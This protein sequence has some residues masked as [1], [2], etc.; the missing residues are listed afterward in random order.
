MELEKFKVGTLLGVG[1]AAIVGLMVLTTVYLNYLSYSAQDIIQSSTS[2][3]FDVLTIQRDTDELFSALEDVE[4]MQDKGE[5]EAARVRFE[6]LYRRA[7]ETVDR[8]GEEGVFEEEEVVQAEK[9]LRDTREVAERVFAKKGA[10]IERREE[11]NESGDEDVEV[12]NREFKEMNQEFINA[13]NVGFGMSSL[14]HN[15]IMRSDEEFNGAMDLVQR[16]Q[17][18]TWVVVGVSVVMAITMGYFI[19]RFAKRSYDIK[20]EFIY[21]VAHDL[22]NPVVAII[23]YL[24]LIMTTKNMSR[25]QM[26]EPLQTIEV[27][28]QRL[29]TQIANM[30]EVGRTETGF[31]KLK[32]ESVQVAPVIEESVMRAKAL[33][34][35]KGL[36]MVYEQVAGKDVYVLADRSKL[37]DVL[38]NLISNA[39]KYNRE[40]GSVT[41][42]TEDTGSVFN[43][44]VTDTGH[45][46]PE[47]KR[48]KL[49]KKYSR[50]EAKT[51]KGVGGTG[52]GLYT[53]KL[54]MEKMEGEISFESVVGEGTTFTVTLKKASKG[55]EK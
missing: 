1:I 8:A 24:E 38:D 35:V 50:L 13:R 17:M 22:R 16:S 45:G 19:V 36:K 53:A 49:F 27:S 42:S 25:A 11:V 26:Q 2:R 44:S 5:V 39:V 28:A 55:T 21:V 9:V 37:S 30:L 3:I 48:D 10:V 33:V 7:E 52:L 34:E 12:D 31:L 51:E 23:G 32:L 54:S 43:I 15:V 18:V 40:K 4:V 14:V 46:I 6:E 41:I 29:R 47:D 20:N